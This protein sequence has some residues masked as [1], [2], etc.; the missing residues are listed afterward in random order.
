MH[1]LDISSWLSDEFA[2]PALVGSGCAILLLVFFLALRILRPKPKPKPLPVDSG[3][4]S[5]ANFDPFVS[6]SATEK[7]AVIR[8]KGNPVKVVIRLS[9]SPDEEVH[10]TVIDRSTGGLALCVPV[11][12]LAETRIQVR[13]DLETLIV[14]WVELEVRSARQEN[15]EWLLGCKFVESPPWS[16]LVQ[17]G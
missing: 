6:G 16:L 15:R 17:F 2:L 10:G 14:Q 3:P 13:P 8:R 7:R 1:D 9:D 4:A 11:E 12:F 5:P